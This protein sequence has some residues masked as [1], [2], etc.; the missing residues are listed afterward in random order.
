MRIVNDHTSKKVEFKL[1]TTLGRRMS[2][3]K[4]LT[5]RWQCLGTDM[6]ER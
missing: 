4:K 5:R 3:V 2:P 1:E 6:S